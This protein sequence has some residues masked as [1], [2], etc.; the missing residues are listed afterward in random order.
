MILII[1]DSLALPRSNL[2][3]KSTW[4]YLLKSQFHQYDIVDKSDYG[5]T[6]LLL[7][8]PDRL[9]YYKP[10]I[11]I[12]QLGICDCAPRYFKKGTFEERIIRLMPENFRKK[13][14]SIVK[15]TRS[16]SDKRAYVGAE[17]FE[18][19]FTDYIKRAIDLNIEKVLVVKIG[20]SGDAHIKAN[21]NVQ[22]SIDKYNMILENISKSFPKLEL[23]DPIGE[24]FDVNKITLED[25]YHLNELGHRVVFEYINRQLCY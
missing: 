23:I 12:I 15:K 3:Y 2:P 18:K 6:S 22:K 19:N 9:E 7:N 13:Y 1:G 8:S 5:A 25:G 16:Q 20:K 10:N 21:S 24:Y 11:I 14:I 17:T 4:I